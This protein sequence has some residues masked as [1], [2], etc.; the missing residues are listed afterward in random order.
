[1]PQ[2]PRANPTPRDPPARHC[3]MR[4]DPKRP[5]DP[6]SARP[7]TLPSDKPRSRR[8]PVTS[9]PTRQAASPPSR[10]CSPR[11][12]RQAA[13]AKAVPANAPNRTTATSHVTAT[14]A[15]RRSTDEAR[16]SI[17]T[18]QTTQHRPRTTRQSNPPPG[19]SPTKPHPRDTTTQAGPAQ[20]SATH[21]AAPTRVAATTPASTSLYDT[22]CHPKP[23][24]ARPSPSRLAVSPQTTPV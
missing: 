15:L 2:R 1:M 11:A 10:P 16:R 22:T 21:L 18:R 12:K 19:A 20:S 24:T 8:R 14:H 13:P 9:T 17:P 4:H 23:G 6:L 3:T 7:L 5:T